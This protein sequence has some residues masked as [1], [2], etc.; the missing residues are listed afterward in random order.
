MIR[1]VAAGAVLVVLVA[2]FGFLWATSC[3][4]IPSSENQNG[5][6]GF[7]IWAG[8]TLMSFEHGIR[9]TCVPAGW[10]PAGAT[11][12]GPGWAKFQGG[13]TG[14]VIRSDAFA[15]TTMSFEK[16]AYRV[17]LVY[18]K[19][20]DAALLPSFKAVV[21]NAFERTGAEFGDSA[22]N[23]PRVHTVLITAGLG[24]DFYEADAVYPDPGPDVS[25]FILPPSSI[26][27]EELFTHAVQHLYN[28]ERPELDAYENNQAPFTR[29]N[30][31][32][33]EATW[34]ETAFRL[35][36][37]G[38][39]ARLE[40]L[41]NVHTAVQTD[42]YALIQ[43]PPFNDEAGFHKIQH[44]VLMNANSTYLDDQYGV[45]VLTPLATVATEGMLQSFHPDAD[46][47]TIFT[48]IHTGEAKNFFDELAKY[49]P[50]DALA[51]VKS[52]YFE[53]ATVPKDLVFAGAAYYDKR[54]AK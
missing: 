23:E 20:L 34:S 28:R 39:R 27:G 48:A 26:R 16:S 32:E 13:M 53:G 17:T 9:P 35:S 37:A 24:G 5:S 25:Y 42:N 11:S 19:S 52:W 49:L 14:V 3:A 43:E 45:Y 46:L 54:G 38:R 4:L 12:A 6:H 51:K 36:N 22:S 30:W 10:E 1:I 7:R 29:D 50:A 44:T 33:L 18:P 15:S 8:Q 31:Q 2:G 40:Y 41:Y 21:T 47:E